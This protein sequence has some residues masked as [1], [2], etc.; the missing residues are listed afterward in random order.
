MSSPTS[1]TRDA[2]SPARRAAVLVAMLA[3]FVVAPATS[4]LADAAAVHRSANLTV[5]SGTTPTAPTS[6]A[7]T[8]VQ[9]SHYDNE[10]GGPHQD[11][12]EEMTGR[13]VSPT[14]VAFIAGVIVVTAAIVTALAVRARRPRQAGDGDL[15]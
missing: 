15:Q 14:R 8:P 2:R 3:L 10:I 13:A 12:P 1:R 7:P 4:A 6:E 9:S 11:T 5:G